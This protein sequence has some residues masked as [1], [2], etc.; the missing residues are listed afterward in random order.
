MSLFDMRGVTNGRVETE[1]TGLLTQRTSVTDV[2]D[3]AAILNKH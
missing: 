2:A 1:E 3:A